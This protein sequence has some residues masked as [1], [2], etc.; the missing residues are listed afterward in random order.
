[1]L[2]FY[3]EAFSFLLGLLRNPLLAKEEAETLT[4]R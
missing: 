2:T 4:G 1:M 3:L